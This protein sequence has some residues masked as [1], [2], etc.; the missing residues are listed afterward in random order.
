MEVSEAPAEN[1]TV[2]VPQISYT[3]DTSLWGLH[4]ADAGIPLQ[5]H[6]VRDPQ[7]RRERHQLR[8]RDGDYRTYLRLGRNL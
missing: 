1:L 3:H 2:I 8:Q 7:V 4:G 6:P 5:V